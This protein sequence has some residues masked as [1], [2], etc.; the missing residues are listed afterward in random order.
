MFSVKFPYQLPQ[1]LTTTWDLIPS[2]LLI[3]KT[4][5]CADKSGGT[6]QSSVTGY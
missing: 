1:P 3:E 5:C 2:D 6:V 4:L